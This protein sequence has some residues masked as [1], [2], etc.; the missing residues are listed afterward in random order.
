LGPSLNLNGSYGLLH[1]SSSLRI[2]FWGQFLVEG[3][4][5]NN[6]LLLLLLLL[7]RLL[8]T[9]V[10]LNLTEDFCAFSSAVRQMPG[11]NPQRQGT[12]S[13]VPNICVVLCIF[14]IVLCIFVL[15]YV[16]FVLFDVF[17]CC[18]IIDMDMSNGRGLLTVRSDDLTRQIVRS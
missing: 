4:I 14:C 1:L 18:S 8:L 12:A 2:R 13:T 15:F 17:V 16:F 6:S 10:F 9:E 7:L 5:K 11:Y 3:D